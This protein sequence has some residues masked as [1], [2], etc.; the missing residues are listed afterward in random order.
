MGTQSHRQVDQLV[1]AGTSN[2]DTISF[3]GPT[4]LPGVTLK[5]GAPFLE[6]PCSN[7]GPEGRTRDSRIPS[8]DGLKRASTPSGQT[9]GWGRRR[10]RPLGPPLPRGSPEAPP[11]SQGPAPN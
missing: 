8:S 11:R 10:S 7:P 6:I 4:T 1:L 9:A 2:L 3:R 5:H